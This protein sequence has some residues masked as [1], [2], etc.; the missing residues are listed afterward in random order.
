LKFRDYLRIHSEARDEYAV[1]KKKI[2]GSEDANQKSDKSPFT[3]YTVR[4]RKFIDNVIKSSGFN[5]LRVLKCAT[6]GEWN[7]AKKFRKKHTDQVIDIGHNHEHFV[8]YRGV[9][10]IGYAD[11]FIASKSEAKLSVFENPDPEAIP[12]FLNVIK[13]WMKIRGYDHDETV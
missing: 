4:K 7:A 9:E 6:E 13:A 2:L 10:I 12:Y 3:V 1:L 11:I 8:L 5:R